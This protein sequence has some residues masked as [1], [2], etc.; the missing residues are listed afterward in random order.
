MSE[1]NQKESNKKKINQIKAFFNPNNSSMKKSI[2]NT[3]QFMIEANIKQK[4]DE[5]IKYN[6]QEIPKK[7]VGKIQTNNKDH[8]TNEEEPK[9]I[10]KALQEANLNAEKSTC[11]LNTKAKK[12][13]HQEKSKKVAIKKKKLFVSDIDLKIKSKKIMNTKNKI[14]SEDSFSINKYKEKYHSFYGIKV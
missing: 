7:E 1:E 6:L 12:T 4:I 3:N 9:K 13:K 10:D 8:V 5:N 2:F 14:S 11:E